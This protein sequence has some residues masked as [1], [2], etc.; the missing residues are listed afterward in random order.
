MLIKCPGCGIDV[1][2]D[3]LFCGNCGYEML[4]TILC[5]GCAKKVPEKKEFCKFC[6]V[7]VKLELQLSKERSQAKK[8]EA[9]EN[10][11]SVAKGVG[12]AAV[13]V[14][15]KVWGCLSI[16]M[17]VLFGIGVLAFVFLLSR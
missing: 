9:A 14:G 6:G 13:V 15:S 7:N 1:L 3:Q 11:K 5:P 16:L 4:A 17:V 2:E 8:E 10:I 12:R